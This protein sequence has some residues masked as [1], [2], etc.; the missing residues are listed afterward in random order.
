MTVDSED[1]VEAFR[2]PAGMVVRSL[3]AALAAKVKAEVVARAAVTAVWEVA[4]EVVLVVAP[5]ALE[6]TTAVG[7]P[8][9][10]KKLLVSR[11]SYFK[12]RKCY[13]RKNYI[14]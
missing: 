9:A 4:S 8:A 1:S 2:V 7:S 3:V 5:E 6:E 11:P 13:R 12:E 14:L 10:S